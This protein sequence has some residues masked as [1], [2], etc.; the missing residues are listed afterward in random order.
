MW[1]CSPLMEGH[2]F[3]FWV[4]GK[5]AV[6]AICSEPRVPIL[7]CTGFGRVLGALDFGLY[8]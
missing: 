4:G 8:L 2:M 1:E 3:R 7:A 6:T 5:P